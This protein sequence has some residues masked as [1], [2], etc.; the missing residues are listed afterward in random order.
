MIDRSLV[1]RELNVPRK[2]T[3]NETM[4]SRRSRQRKTEQPT[5]VQASS[6]RTEL[7]PSPG[8]FPG[9]SDAPVPDYGRSTVVIDPPGTSPGCWAGA[10][11]ATL[12]PDGNVYLAYRLRRPI[13]EGRGYANVI[14]RSSDGLHFEELLVLHREQF[15]CESLERP[16]LVSDPRGG[17]RIYV[18]CATPGTKHWRVDVLEAAAPEQFEP[19]TRKTVLPGDEHQ[20]LKDPVVQ[21]DGRKWNMWVCSHPL[22][23]PGDEDRM[24]TLY[25]TSD[26]GIGWQLQGVA[27]EPKAGRWDSRGTRIASVL[28]HRP[29]PVAY[30]DGRASSSQNAEELTGIAVKTQAGD[31]EPVGNEPLSVLPFGTG[32][33]RYIS[34][35]EPYGGGYRMYYE[36]SRRDGAHDLRTEYVPDPRSASQSSNESPVSLSS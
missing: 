4:A 30:Y 17:W 6:D 13:G 16:A 9:V 10:P 7:H 25:M 34:V 36:T 12:G 24:R 5:G 8:V 3:D 23:D 22:D 1:R 2:V 21:Y 14:A 11:S 15:D 19:S 32:S 26:D 20:G 28:N 31:F 29:V 35:V 27:M 18:S 33:L